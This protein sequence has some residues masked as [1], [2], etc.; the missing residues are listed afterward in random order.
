MLPVTSEREVRGVVDCLDIVS[1]MPSYSL[2]NTVHCTKALSMDALQEGSPSQKGVP[3]VDEWDADW[4][5]AAE[6]NAEVSL[7]Q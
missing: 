1:R 3:A 6:L 5:G 4:N 7:Y 2:T